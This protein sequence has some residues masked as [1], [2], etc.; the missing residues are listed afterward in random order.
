MFM[1]NEVIGNKKHVIG[2]NPQKIM[3]VGL[4]KGVVIINLKHNKV[5]FLLQMTFLQLIASSQ[6]T[7]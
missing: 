1:Y 4:I 3:K 6:V 5:H 7:L 2:S